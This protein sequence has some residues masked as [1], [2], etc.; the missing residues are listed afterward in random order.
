[1]ELSAKSGLEEPRRRID[2][3]NTHS[4]CLYQCSMS[5]YHEF[6]DL[7]SRDGLRALSPELESFHN[8]SSRIPDTSKAPNTN[9]WDWLQ[10]LDW[11]DE[12]I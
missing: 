10:S 2:K 11:Q 6:T 8:R 3:A 9:A 12:Y 4:K 7:T 1:M 5:V